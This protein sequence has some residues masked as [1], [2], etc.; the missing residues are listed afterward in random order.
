MKLQVIRDKQ[1][2]NSS[3]KKKYFIAKDWEAEWQASDF[4]VITLGASGQ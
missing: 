2:S 3:R 4:S 1:S